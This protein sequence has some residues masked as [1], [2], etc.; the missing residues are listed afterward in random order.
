MDLSSKRLIVIIGLP[1]SGKST[2]AKEFAENGYEIYDD[3][4]WEFL[5]RKLLRAINSGAKVC[6]NDP[7]LC[8]FKQFKRYM[9]DITKYIKLEEIV[10][11]LFKNDLSK[12]IENLNERYET[13]SKTI[14]DK[15]IFSL[16][17]LSK[18]YDIENYMN[19]GYDVMVKDTW[20][21]S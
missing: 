3:F 6:I 17:Q 8:D 14:R 1:G 11:I 18:T 21:K 16:N 7:R 20:S 4:I 2:F 19:I 12:S 5:N 10:L 13:K 15:V 9:E